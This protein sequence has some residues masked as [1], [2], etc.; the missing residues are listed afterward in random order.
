MM[1]VRALR[2]ER[3]SFAVPGLVIKAGQWSY[4]D[5]TVFEHSIA[6]ERLPYDNQMARSIL[7]GF[8]PRFR[9]AIVQS[10]SVLKPLFSGAEGVCS[11]RIMRRRDMLIFYG[12]PCSDS[13]DK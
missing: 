6:N 11:L 1:I 2:A 12:S 3:L 4:E 13:V 5:K 7:T 8:V 9:A 10:G